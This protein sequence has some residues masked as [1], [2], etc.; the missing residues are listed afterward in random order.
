M[1]N[2]IIRLIR[3]GLFLPCFEVANPG[4]SDVVVRPKYLS[5]CAA[6]QRYF[7]GNRPPEV[8]KEKLPLA[9]FHECVAEVI[10]DPQDRLKKGSLCVLLP[11]GL[12]S[13]EKDSNYRQGAFFRSSNADG[14][15]QEVMFLDREELIPLPDGA[16][17]I[18]VF[19]ELMSVCCQA[20]RRLLQAPPVKDKAK[21]GIWGDG[22][23]A[24]MMA[25]ALSQLSPS[26]DIYIYGKHDEKLINFSFV[27]KRINIFDKSD[28]TTIDM[29]FECVGGSGSQLAIAHAIEK[30][31][32]RGTLVLMGVSETAPTVPTRTILE[33]G[34]S[35]L[36]CSRSTKNDFRKAID[37]ISNNFVKNTLYK[38]ISSKIIVSSSSDLMDAFLNDKNLDYKTIISLHL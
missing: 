10:R 15:C 17:Y 13:Q 31:S 35:L 21:I 19:T 29:A 20:Y 25:I 37:I 16:D 23:M 14:F 27:K 4:P 30:L 7:Q 26:S 28:K 12:A 34:L 6:D 22:A 1:I 24:F 32:P 8:L 33:K 3:P 5:I 11:G 9:L 38:I 36:G 2:Q 18:Y